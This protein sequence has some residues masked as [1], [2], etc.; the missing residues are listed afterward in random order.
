MRTI[1]QIQGSF[2]YQTSNEFA[3]LCGLS[4][5]LGYKNGEIV[6]EG[7]LIAQ[8]VGDFRDN[9]LTF[10]TSLESEE[11]IG[12][13]IGIFNKVYD[14]D[15]THI[16][17]TPYCGTHIVNKYFHS[18]SSS[19]GLPSKI[20]NFKEK[21]VKIPMGTVIT[22][23]TEY[24]DK[25]TIDRFSLDRAG[26]TYGGTYTGSEWMCSGGL[27]QF[28][29]LKYV[30][31]KD[32]T[33]ELPFTVGEVVLII[34]LGGEVVESSIEEIYILN[35]GEDV[36]CKL[37]WHNR[38]YK[39]LKLG[40][41]KTLFF[42]KENK[43]ELLSDIDEQIKSMEIKLLNNSNN[44]SV[45]DSTL[46]WLTKLENVELPESEIKSLYDYNASEKEILLRRKKELSVNLER[47]KTKYNLVQET[48]NI[49]HEKALL[50]AN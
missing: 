40:T 1:K 34:N 38:G 29:M 42:S 41:L 15:D 45:K 20:E 35:A 48:Q 27:E 32:F 43:I 18:S 23:K 4:S 13:L 21:S 46:T 19:W 33:L 3:A 28:E 49:V 14:T 9:S 26:V 31:L 24:S 50:H 2:P 17:R 37:L 22:Y 11:I 5:T 10:K 44:I 6:Y 16:E 47:L 30:P 7:K 39:R 25:F 8:R 36:K 12:T